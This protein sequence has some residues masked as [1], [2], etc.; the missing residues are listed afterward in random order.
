MKK[1]RLAF[2]DVETTG[3]DP[4]IHEVYEIA[5]VFAE[6]SFDT[7]GN[8]T[9]TMTGE[10]EIL[11]ATEHIENA[12]PQ[13]LAVGMYEN[14]NWTNAVSQKVGLE[15]AARLLKDCV[16]VAQNV[17][18]DWTFLFM[19][20]KRHGVDFER[21]LYYQKLDLASMVFG[22]LYSD[23]RLLKFTL[24][25]LSEYFGVKNINAHTALSDARTAFAIAKK[26]LER[27]A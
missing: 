4:S 21:S 11:L 12:E 15:K 5:I 8:V 27:P 19:N 3:L 23:K 7:E 25:E 26:V 20:G 1:H 6:Q 14:R 18:F 2:V 24:R 17:T 10:E 22:K 9:L 13:A 16:F